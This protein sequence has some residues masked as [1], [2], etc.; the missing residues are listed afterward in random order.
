MLDC[1]GSKCENPIEVIRT[2]QDSI[3]CLQP[4]GDSYTRRSIFDS[5][6][7]GCIPVFFHPGSAYA[8]YTWY[9]PKNYSKYSVFIPDHS[10][11][12]GKVSITEILSR[13]SYSNVKAMRKEVIEL[14]PK[15]VYGDFSFDGEDAFSIAVNEVIK[16]VDGVRRRIGEGLDPEIGFGE[17]NSWKLKLNGIERDNEFDGFF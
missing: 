13:I 12:T 14:I 10:V 3:F 9:F 15:I 16:R 2:F 17:V 1:S 4:E 7:S 6:L 8:Q 5:I 11:K